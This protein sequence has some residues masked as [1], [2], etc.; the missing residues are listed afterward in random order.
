MLDFLLSKKVIEPIII[1]SITSLVYLIINRFVKNILNLRLKNIDEK[2]NKTLIMLITNLIKYFLVFIAIIMILNVY[3]VNTAAFITSLGVVG[4]VA[5]LALQDILKDLFAGFSIILE[6]QYALGDTVTINNFK[7]EVIGLGI[8]TTKLRSFTGEVC[9]ISN[10]NV[11][12]VINHS[13]AKSLAIVTVDVAYES[14]IQKVEKVLTNLC[15]RLNKELDDLE[16]EVTLN[17]IEALK[18]S[19]IEFKITAETKPLKHHDIMRK[20]RR[21]IKLELDKNN[22]VI[23][24][25]Q[26]VI[27]HE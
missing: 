11:G 4:V 15:K 16:G 18:D 6:N 22:I 20:I 12:D 2:K 8:K 24:Y 23:P 27:H 9:F 19:S 3:G 26:V 17:G 21:E 5:G 13:L 10:R 14:D 25:P 7:G 1:I